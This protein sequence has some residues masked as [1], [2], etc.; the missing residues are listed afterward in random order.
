MRRT[1]YPSRVFSLLCSNLTT[2][3]ITTTTTSI[4]KGAPVVD[5]AAAL[6]IR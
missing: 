2:I 4:T 3:T 1:I 6:V 5:Q